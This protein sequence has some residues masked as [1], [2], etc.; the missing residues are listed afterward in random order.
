MILASITNLTRLSESWPAE[1]VRTR[2]IRLPANANRRARKF[3]KPRGRKSALFLFRCLKFRIT[4]D[5]AL[6][7]YHVKK[8]SN[9]NCDVRSKITVDLCNTGLFCH[10]RNRASSESQFHGG[11]PKTK[12]IFHNILCDCRQSGDHGSL[13]RTCQQ[14]KFEAHR[15]CAL[16]RVLFSRIV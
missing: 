3:T 7:D 11:A 6:A 14:S 12:S 16:H 13:T 10:S 15:W 2:A 1:P 9:F 5:G 4:N 8:S